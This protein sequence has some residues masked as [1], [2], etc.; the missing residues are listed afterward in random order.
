[1]LRNENFIGNAPFS[2]HRSHCDFLLLH[3]SLCAA[4]ELHTGALVFYPHTQERDAT[5][6]PLTAV[7]HSYQAQT[8]RS[9]RIGDHKLIVSAPAIVEFW[10]EAGL[11]IG[12][13]VRL[14]LAL[15]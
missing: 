10:L 11:L 2:F 15:G 3:H 9:K 12:L 8:Q 13:A 14:R 5:D 4:L 6:A 7:V 1:M